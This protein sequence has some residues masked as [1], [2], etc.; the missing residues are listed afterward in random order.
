M[1]EDGRTSQKVVAAVEA[2]GTTF[3]VAVFAAPV[4]SVWDEPLRRAEMATLRDAQA[5][6]DG[7]VA[8]ISETVAE[9]GEGNDDGCELVGVGVASFG[10]VDLNKTSASYGFI[11][12]TPKAGWANT[13]V[14]GTFAAAFGV[15]VAFET[16]VNAAALAERMAAGAGAEPEDVGDAA[17]VYVTVGTGVGVGV[18]LDAETAVHGLLHPEAGHMCVGMHPADAA[19]GIDNLHVCPFH[20]WCVEGYVASGGLAAR[21]GVAAADLAS[22]PDDD[23]GWDAVA[24]YLAQL[25]INVTLVLSPHT[26]V[27]GGGILKRRSLYA[28]VRSHVHTLLNGYLAVPRIT[29]SIEA[30]LRPPRLAEPGLTGAAL[31]V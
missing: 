30:Y 6:L 28:R 15:P 17:F 10:P 27:L 23:V 20:A 4:T 26:V 1:A 25:V 3:V 8:W 11:T 14:V 31:L 24:W 9:L 7:V 12:T 29:D 18:A 22:V 2:G 13:D 5:T 21:F 16:D 19:A